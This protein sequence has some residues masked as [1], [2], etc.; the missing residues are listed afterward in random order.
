MWRVLFLTALVAIAAGSVRGAPTVEGRWLTQGKSG[1]VEIY[2]CADGSLCGRLAWFRIK[3]TDHNPQLTDLH[4]P[5]PALRTRSLCGLTIMW[6]FQPDGPDRWSGG[7]LYD[8]E[9]GNTYSGNI[10]LNPEGTLMLRGYIGISLFGR[11]E[12]WTRFTQPIGRCPAT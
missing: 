11:S 10:S 4:N 7:S 8:P 9:S 6:G 2:R 1:V 5:D 12:T 3:P